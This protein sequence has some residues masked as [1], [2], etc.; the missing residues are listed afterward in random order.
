MHAAHMKQ[1]RHKQFCFVTHLITTRWSCA[2]S[3]APRSHVSSALLNHDKRPSS[4]CRESIEPMPGTA[5]TESITRFALHARVF[6]LAQRGGYVTLSASSER[7]RGCKVEGVTS[8]PHERAPVC[9]R[10]VGR[11]FMTLHGVGRS[12]A[13]R[14]PS[15]VV[16]FDVR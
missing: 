5:L 3:S 6:A 10:E 14:Q 13:P 9:A 1:G 8:R 16:A 12:Y 2:T 4:N 7:V 15:P 11:L